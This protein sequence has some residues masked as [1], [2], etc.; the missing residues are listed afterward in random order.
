MT[1]TLET[2][3]MIPVEFVFSAC[4][5]AL[6]WSNFICFLPPFRQQLSKQNT[7]LCI[8]A[9]DVFSVNYFPFKLRQLI[10]QT[11]NALCKLSKFNAFK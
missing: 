10:L 1:N 3:V 7:F 6:K 4:S 11:I 9:V 2:K 5:G 8:Y